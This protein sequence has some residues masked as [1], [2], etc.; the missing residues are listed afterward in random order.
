MYSIFLR[1]FE[2]LSLFLY[3]NPTELRSELNANWLTL[4]LKGLCL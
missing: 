4:A 1:A 3:V 2:E